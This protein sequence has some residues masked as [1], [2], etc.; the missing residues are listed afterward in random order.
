MFATTKGHKR[1]F[2]FWEKAFVNEHPQES[3]IENY[4]KDEES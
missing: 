2:C 3:K 4:L 1:Y